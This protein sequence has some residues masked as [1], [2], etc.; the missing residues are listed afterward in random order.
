MVEDESEFEDAEQEQHHH[1]HDHGELDQALPRLAGLA[2]TGPM[3][4]HRIGSM[5][6]T[7]ARSNDI[8]PLDPRKVLTG[9]T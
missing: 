9:V 7:L 5:R 1:G 8:V 2:A 6:M 3:P 4:A